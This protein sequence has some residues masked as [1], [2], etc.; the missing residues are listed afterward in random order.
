VSSETSPGL[1]VQAIDATSSV[2]T[3]TYEALK[4]AIRQVP[5]YDDGVDLR[6]DERRLADDLRVSRTP[7]RQAIVRLEHE[8]LLRT[9]PRVG[10][11]VVRKTKEEI[12]EVITVWAALESM[13]ARLVCERASDAD[14][15]SLRRLFATFDADRGR[16]A[17]T[18][19]EYSEA[20]LEFH[21]RIIELA[22]SELLQRT[23]DGLLVHMQAVRRRT[24]R[25]KERFAHSIVDHM[26][27]I[28]ALEERDLD[29]AERLVRDH[30]LKLAR[31]VDEHVH[32]LGESDRADLADQ[33]EV[34]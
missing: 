18:I 33:A 21:R 26:Q 16:L 29:V 30:A 23:V 27:I 14:V 22:G 10:T 15:A 1:T 13:A 31:H 2:T 7:I 34:G 5:I 6:I 25:E 11:F 19:D 9:I 4:R 32:Y 12:L 20:N 28:E 17:A 8:G 24:I 3:L